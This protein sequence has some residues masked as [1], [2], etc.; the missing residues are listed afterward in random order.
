[1]QYTVKKH[2][3]EEFYPIYQKWL[4]QHNFPILND[5][6]LGENMF[7][8]YREEIPIYAFPFWFTDSKICIIAF[9]AS[10]KKISYN[11]KRGG[12]D[13]L[14]SEIIKYAKRKSMMTIYTTTT[15]D[16]VITSLKNNGFTNGDLDSSQF[17][18]TV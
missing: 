18:K 3:K 14:I 15:T 1:M 11:K 13:F 16:S 2:S 4:E 10:N 8:C 12:L 17:F 6:I 5:K 7:V 9:V